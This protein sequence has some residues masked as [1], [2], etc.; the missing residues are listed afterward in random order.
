MHVKKYV[1]DSLIDTLFNI[2]GKIKYEVNACQDI[3]KIRIHPKLYPRPKGQTTYLPP[4]CYTL[5]KKRQTVKLVGLK[6]HYCYIIKQQ[7]L[8]MTTGDTLSKD[9]IHK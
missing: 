2:K 7:F 3:C 8:L 5:L 4:T 6:S 9:V 1:C